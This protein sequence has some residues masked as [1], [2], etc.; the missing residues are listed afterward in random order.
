[1][2]WIPAGSFSMGSEKENDWAK[3]VHEMKVER[4]ALAR[5]EVTFEEYDRFCEAV[6]REKPKDRG[7][8]RGKR[9]VI[10]VSWRNA[11]AYTEWLSEQTGHAYRLPTEAEWEHAARAGTS[12]AY[13]WGDEASHEYANYGKDKCCGGLALGRDQWEYTA[14]VGS[15]A[16]NPFG[17]YDMAGNVWEWTCS[18]FARPY[19]NKENKCLSKNHAKDDSLLSL[20]GGCWSGNRE[21]M[22]AANRGRD[23]PDFRNDGLGLRPA[24]TE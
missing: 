14:P 6:G 23:R 18:E 22:R 24:R 1:M 19:A 21:D 4:F 11:T 3:P 12:A 5:H 17:V 9:P 7:W 16:G 13:W 8:G 15:F 2:V 10:N 20:R